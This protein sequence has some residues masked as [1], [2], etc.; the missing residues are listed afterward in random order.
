MAIDAWELKSND[1]K[2]T[3]KS[4][5]IK[6]FSLI[7]SESGNFSDDGVKVYS[8]EF[9]LNGNMAREAEYGPDGEL[10]WICAY[11]YDS[12]ER[13]IEETVYTDGNVVEG[14]TVRTYDENSNLIDVAEYG[15]EDEVEFK[16]EFIYEAGRLVEERRK[17]ED[18]K[19]S[20]AGYCKHNYDGEGNRVETLEYDAQNVLVTKMIYKY[21]KK[22]NLIEESTYVSDD[23][24]G[25][26][27]DAT[28]VYTY[29]NQSRLLERIIKNDE[30]VFEKVAY[31]Y[32]AKNNIVEENFFERDDADDSGYETRIAYEYDKDGH[33]LKETEYELVDGSM[34]VMIHSKHV[35]EFHS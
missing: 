23:G 33:I 2:N 15:E 5:K 7:E 29:D 10:D 3:I 26:E 12:K 31:K 27:L 18:D 8:C 35:Y 17:N 6:A 13:L 25:L 32:D 30:M 1:Y 22:K 20:A 21:D 24:D 11:V 9:D 14:K 19:G 4:T 34:N 16:T 28:I